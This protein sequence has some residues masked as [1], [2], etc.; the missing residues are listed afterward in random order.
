MNGA[1]QLIAALAQH[2]VET[3][4]GYPGG[5]IMPVYDALYDSPVNHVLCRHE[6]AAAL[7]ANG[8][9]RA[10]GRVGVC[11]ATSGPGATNLIT[12]LGDA[13][14]DSVPIIAITGQVASPFIGTDAFQE[15]D[16]LGLSLAVTKHSI[17]IESISQLP[18]AVADAFQI[19]QSGRPGPVLIDIP[20]DIQ[21]AE[22]TATMAL[23]SDP[24]S[25]RSEET[26][27]PLAD[28]LAAANSMLNA[29][30]R[31]VAYVGGGVVMGQAETVLSDWLSARGIPVVTTLKGLGAVNAS[32][33]DY[34]GMLG[35]HGTKA[36]NL[37]VNECDL[38]IAL[39]VRF[40]DRVTG[41]LDTFAPD[42]QVIHIDID[43]AELG[44]L[45]HPAVVLAGDVRQILPQLTA[46]PSFPAWQQYCRALRAEHQPHYPTEQEDIDATA[47]L[48]RLSTLCDEQTVISCDVGQH[49]MWVAQH[50]DFSKASNHLSSSG[51]GTMGFG[52]PAAIGAQFA[53]PSD[54]V[55]NV[56][57]DGSFMMNVQELATIRRYQLPIKI[58]LLDN[59]RLGMV[60]QW[61]E[62]FFA[63]RYSETDLSDN[64]EFTEL[65][66]V[67]GIPGQR[68]EYAHQ[69][70]DAL[71]TMLA[72]EGPYLLH[73]RIDAQN[74]VWPLVPPGASNIQMMEARP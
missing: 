67:F 2:G 30:Q 33:P 48:A 8:Y 70:A 51:F 27:A 43:A 5:A 21:Q 50:M 60:R 26:T 69:V 73:V 14:L 24:L 32:N 7:A 72:A 74:N 53:R 56:S 20:K 38:L 52:L 36:A 63:E 45:R 23:V 18:Q 16:M 10:S 66:H 12:G 25:L 44:K 1:Q 28:Q 19:A 49:Q 64:P 62:L 54:T 68:I 3:I 9:A 46:T 15:V 59:E 42:A 47:L 55:I 37:A 39:G 65:G 22:V 4:F 29:A 6:Q 40:D 31:P 13:M 35:M 61:Q 17:L 71:A 58:L 57:G 11:M 41:K 34:L